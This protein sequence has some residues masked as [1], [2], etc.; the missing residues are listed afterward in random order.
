MNFINA[1]I[2]WFFK[3]RYPQIERFIQN[4]ERIQDD[5]FYDLIEKA[6]QT[7]W[8][9]KHEYSTIKSVHEYKNRVP[10][11]TYED[12][13]PFVDRLLAGE[14]NILWP[15]KITWFAKS[16]GTTSDRSK[17][18]PVSK[19]AMEECHFKGGRDLVAIYLQNN[20]SSELFRGRGIILGGS[21]QV[22]KI[23][24]KTYYGDVS[25]VLMQNMPLI[26]QFISAPNKST[27]LLEDFEK[28]INLIA[29]ETVNKNITHIT[30]V[31][32]WA[33]VLIKK[34][35]EIT[36]KDN[37]MDVW[38]NLELYIHGGVS[39]TPYIDQFR[40]LIKSD[41]MRYMETYNAS[42]GFFGI[43]HSL[44]RN[45]MLLMLDYGIFYE[46]CPME[47]VGKIYPKT[48]QLNQVEVGKNYAL[49]I[50]TNAGLWRYMIG[51][52]IQFTSVFP[53]R[54]KVSG[55]TKHF[56]NAF[57]EEVIVENADEAVRFACEKNNASIVDYTAGPV[58][59]EG[60]K[61]G[62]HEWIIEFEKPPED[63]FQYAESLDKRL[64]E[65]NSDYDA[66]RYKDMALG[67]PKINIARKDLFHDWLKQK[68]KLGGQNKI[69]R[70]ANNRNYIEELLKM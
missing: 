31:P 8:G 10:V 3:Q 32:T 40:Q 7:K 6:K 41:S 57:G 19:E 5:I 49:I 15:S 54:I 45:D 24:D 58:Y 62:G 4:P 43:Q 46:F 29:H 65:I 52:T 53:F 12:L 36:G 59:F 23:N 35:F 9:K 13:K 66:K 63:L 68:G 51:D 14:Q 16:S 61:K 39:F 30:G 27:V 34:V 47:E 18:I 20:P 21:T 11:S 55:R 26:G 44:L 42:E 56:I 28:K 33:I 17:F 1:I 64:R 2:S 60:N 50:T 67:M 25:A 38:P 37:L 22:N 69:P 70:L 48:L